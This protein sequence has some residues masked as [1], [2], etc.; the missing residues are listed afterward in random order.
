MRGQGGRW[1]LVV[2]GGCLA[3]LLAGVTVGP[4]QPR[5]AAAPRSY[6]VRGVAT[7]TGSA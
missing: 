5:A 1:T 3:L 7:A 2:A 6:V 4:S